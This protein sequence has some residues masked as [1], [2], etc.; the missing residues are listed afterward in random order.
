MIVTVSFTIGINL[1]TAYQDGLEPEGCTRPAVE[2]ITNRIN[3]NLYPPRTEY[4]K[5]EILEGH[6]EIWGKA[7]KESLIEIILNTY[8]VSQEW[9]RSL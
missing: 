2:G 3:V 7:E 8:L 4:I 1:R 5:G 6:A 9:K